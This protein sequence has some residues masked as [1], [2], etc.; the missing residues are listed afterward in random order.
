MA[1]KKFT[2]L[3]TLT[4]A[5]TDDV[6][7]IVDTSA[8]TSKQIA[9]SGL[10]AAIAS[11]FADGAITPA[12]R[13]GG[14]YV[15]LHT[16][17][18]GTGSEAITGVGFK[19]KAVLAFGSETSASSGTQKFAFGCAYDNSGTPAHSRFSM[20]LNLSTA[21]G[22]SSDGTSVLVSLVN[23]GGS[24]EFTCA[25]TSFDSD[26]ITVNKTVGGSTADRRQYTLMFFG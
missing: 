1:N 2:D 16:F 13:S 25:V 4:T 7:A 22:D 23:A 11:S 6:L 26:G 3:A 5:A 12:K 20:G 9:V 15:K 18:S 17:S 21:V 19:P 24:A 8:N 10:A 14:F